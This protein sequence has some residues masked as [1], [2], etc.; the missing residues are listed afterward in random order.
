[1]D[2]VRVV[3]S[4]LDLNE[5]RVALPEYR[6]KLP[7]GKVSGEFRVTGRNVESKSWADWPLDVDGSVRVS[8]AEYKVPAASPQP[9]K[10]NAT[11]KAAGPSA[12]DGSFLPDGHLTRRLRLKVAADIAAVVKDTLTLKGVRAAGTIGDGHYRG[13]VVVSEI[14]GGSVK[15]SALDVPLLQTRPQLKGTVEGQNLVIQDALAFAKPELKDFASGRMGGRVSFTTSMP[16]EPDFL[17]ALKASGGIVL[18]PVTLNSVKVGQMLNDLMDKIPAAARTRLHLQPVKVDPL[19]G[20]VKSDFTLRAQVMTIENFLAQDIE[21]SE[22][23]LQG[24]VTVPAL[25]GDL[26]G[27]FVWAKPQLQGCLL[28]GNSDAQGRMLVPV[29]IKGD[30][31][32]PG[33]SALSDLVNKLVNGALHCEQKKLVERVKKEGTKKIEQEVK[34]QLQGLFGK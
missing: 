14:F 23:H 28:E 31:M 1:L 33:F 29:A 10:T 7:K 8:M 34:K 30:L 24:K 32:H 20:L 19:K 13:G 17:A 22:L 25:Q 18:Q 15:I 4:G 21:G 27:Q 5:L 9:E 6:E 26:A 3:L 11:A 12:D 2:G 16:S